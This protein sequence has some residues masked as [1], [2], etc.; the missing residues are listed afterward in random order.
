MFSVIAEFLVNTKTAFRW[1]VKAVVSVKVVERSSSEYSD[2][3]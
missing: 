1:F 2:K 3:L